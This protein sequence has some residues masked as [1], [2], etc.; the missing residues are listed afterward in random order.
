MKR[1]GGKCRVNQRQ[2]EDGVVGEM[3]SMDVHTL[4]DQ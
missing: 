3:I 2:T 1:E 4:G